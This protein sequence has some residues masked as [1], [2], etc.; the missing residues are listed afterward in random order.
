M[1]QIRKINTTAKN[2]KEKW[3]N[4][5]WKMHFTFSKILLCILFSIIPGDKPLLN[6]NIKVIM[7]EFSNIFDCNKII[8]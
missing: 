7:L 2:L 8:W 1:W 6:F 3:L 4:E 5:M